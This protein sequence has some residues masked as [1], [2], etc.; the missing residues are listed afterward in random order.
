MTNKI[1]SIQNYIDNVNYIG[2]ISI[3]L[4]CVMLQL[5]MKQIF[6]GYF[7]SQ[8]FS[9]F[10]THLVQT[11]GS[12]K[13]WNLFL[14]FLANHSTIA[15]PVILALTFI[16][17][18]GMFFFANIIFPLIMTIIFAAFWASA[19]ADYWA[20]EL[21]LPCLFALL[22]ML[23]QH[24]L[25]K[26]CSFKMN[27]GYKL[28]PGNGKLLINLICILVIV[29][30][31]VYF[32]FLSK[33]GGEHSMLLSW[34]FPGISGIAILISLQFDKFRQVPDSGKIAL[35]N[36]T[37]LTIFAGVVGLM[38]VYQVQ[39]NE[40]LN[41]FTL[42][43]Y[44]E[45][46]DG[47]KATTNAPD[48]IKSGLTIASND[49]S[50]LL[51]LQIVFEYLAAIFLFLGMFRTPIY[52]LTTGLLGM[53]MIIEFGAIGAVVPTPTSEVNWL[54]ELLLPTT[55]LFICSIH[56]T[57]RFFT[58]TG[59]KR[60]FLGYQIFSGISFNTKVHICVLLSGIFMLSLAEVYSVTEA[61]YSKSVL[62]GILLFILMIIIDPLRAKPDY[63]EIK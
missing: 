16:S 47:F 63:K 57:S 61:T 5:I 53:L 48:I 12:V 28:L 46:I 38:L 4:A 14:L 9:D 58:E 24:G 22:V 13:I 18:F 56:A 23:G 55:I 39:E 52:W 32:S 30:A 17:V 41:S 34:L 25:Y 42:K 43:G 21:V 8:G 11:N 6:L 20:F 1:R 35:A 15:I 33:N 26:N 49:A 36:N 60:K 31:L 7:S 29:A 59:F 27:L 10:V 19:N 62:Y 40:A 50:I 44:K 45:V 2:I 37:Y 3:T 51:P 54:W